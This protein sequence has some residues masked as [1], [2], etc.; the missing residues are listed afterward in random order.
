MISEEECFLIRIQVSL[1]DIEKN[2]D[3]LYKKDAT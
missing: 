1:P 3:Q 2:C